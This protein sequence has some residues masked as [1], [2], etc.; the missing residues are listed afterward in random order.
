MRVQPRAT[1]FALSVLWLGLL[2]DNLA[3]SSIALAQSAPVSG[4]WRAGATAIDVQVES[5]GGDCG[6]RPQS[7]HSA[8]GG[9]V[10]VEQRDQ[11]LLVHGRDQDI[12]SDACWSR[13]PAIK[14][15]SAS[16][17]GGVWTTHCKTSDA[18]PK[19]E[20]GTYSLKLVSSDALLYQDVSHYDWSLN[21]SKCVATFT[22]SQTLSRAANKGGK[23]DPI[24]KAIAP[25]KIDP[26]ASA[27][28]NAA[29]EERACTPGAP[30]HLVLRPHHIDIEV[31]QRT[32]FHARVTDATDCAIREPDIEWLLLHNKALRGSLGA[33]C[34]TAATSAA[35]AQGDF[36]IVARLV[37]TTS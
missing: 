32:C 36:K 24:A 33:G 4:S 17:A 18:D 2:F 34:F 5:W 35:E 26:Y 1:S 25:Q 8:G 28:A 20:Q 6:P 23:A 7:T 14:R 29:S 19:A 21:E 27:N 13:N 15:T 11:V 12:R 9:L 30:A 16:Y 22:T 31:G 37:G 3:A 10:T